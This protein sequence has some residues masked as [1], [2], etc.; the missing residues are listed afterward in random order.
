[1]KVMKEPLVSVVIPSYNGKELTVN[2]LK[3]I[4]KTTYKNY[5]VVVVDNGSNDGCYEYVKKNYPYVKAVKV[6]VNKGIARG[7]NAGIEKSKG[8][9]LVMMNN[10][11]VVD[12]EWLTYLVEAANSDKKIGIVGYALLEFGLKKDII[13]R[14]GYSETG[15]ILLRFEAVGKG[16]EHKNQ[17]PEVLPVDHTFGLVKREVIKKI[18]AF[19]EKTF[20]SWDEVDLCYRARKI[21]Y[22]TVAATKSKV[23]HMGSIT[24]KKTPYLRVFHYHKNRIRF[25]LK[26]LSPFRKLVNLP[27]TIGYYILESGISLVKGDFKNSMAIWN[28]IFWNIRNL[29]DYF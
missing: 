7:L 6:E 29:R 3:S 26:H 16:Q 24:V 11:M 12:P 20:M 14:L 27:L 25:I 23:Y 4:K 21:G 10:D 13:Q 15:K 17:F 28:A 22:T 9:Y 18:G 5:E 19:D 1:M 2:L 8:E